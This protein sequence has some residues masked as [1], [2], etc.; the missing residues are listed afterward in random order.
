MHPHADVLVELTPQ[1][2]SKWTR[3]RFTLQ[4]SRA[5]KDFLLYNAAQQVD[6]IKARLPAL[7]AHFRDAVSPEGG[8]GLSE[9]RAEAACRRL[10]YLSYGLWD[11]LLAWPDGDDGDPMPGWVSPAD[12]I[13]SLT[14]LLAPLIA[15][16]RT[17]VDSPLVVELMASDSMPFTWSL[18][19]E[20][21]PLR[22]PLRAR[23]TLSGLGLYEALHAFLG[24]QAIV[25]RRRRD[26]GKVKLRRP[27]KVP[28]AIVAYCGEGILPGIKKQLKFFEQS[29]DR[30]EL[31]DDSLWPQTATLNEDLAVDQLGEVVSEARARPE[32]GPRGVLHFCCHYR[33]TAATGPALGIT[34]GVAVTINS[35]RGSLGKTRR[36]A[37][38]QTLVFLNACNSAA[39]DR[40]DDS[41]LSLLFHSG[42]RHVIGGES[43]LPDLVAS[44]FACLMYEYALDG[45]SVGMAFWRARRH[46]LERFRNPGGLLYTLYGSP[47]IHLR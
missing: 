29:Q 26:G 11:L 18:P 14:T 2:A 42:Y 38:V 10:E 31:D 30:I 21:L 6:A 25:V 32:N 22:A 40:A 39:F 45:E 12:F 24:M 1:Q 4:D 46:L 27:A 19:L 28:M 43:L 7:L 35:L 47:D 33:A 13:E 41:L 9:S 20:L 3:L 15:L 34:A 17:S 44:Q 5:T 16:K 37:D 8:M 36:P 23:H